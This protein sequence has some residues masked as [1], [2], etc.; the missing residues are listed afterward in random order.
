[1]TLTRLLDD[2]DLHKLKG[3]DFLKN[4]PE[5]ADSI[6]TVLGLKGKQIIEFENVKG[7]NIYGTMD[8]ADILK[9]NESIELLRKAD[10]L[11]TTLNEPFSNAMINKITNAARG[12]GAF[13]P[14]EVFDK[15]ISNGSLRQLDSF[16]K[17]VDDFDQHLMKSGESDLATN[18]NRVKTQTAQRLFKNA[19]ED[20]IDPVTNEIN[21]TV[22]AKHILK[23]ESTHP[24]K[25]DSLFRAPDGITSG[26]TIVQTINQ[27]IKISPKLKADNVE[28]LISVFR[29]QDGLNTT[30]K[31]KAFIT[32]LKEQAE[33]SA[34]EADL[35][36]NRNLSE[37]PNRTPSE[38][39]E[40][41]FRP[42]NSQNIIK[43][44]QMMEPDDFAKVKEA[45]LGKLLEDAIDYNVKSGFVTDIFKSKN[46]NTALNKYSDET[47]EAM[48]GKEFTKDIKH[49]ADTIDALTKGEIGRGNFPGALV[50]AGIAAGVVFAPLAAI[51]TI[52]GLQIA[53]SLLGSRMFIKYAS[54]TDKGSIIKALEILRT[55]AA[56]FGYRFING[57]LRQVQDNTSKFIEENVPDTD[58]NEIMGLNKQFDAPQTN[59][60]L[61]QVSPVRLADPLNQSQQDRIEFAEKLFRRPI[62]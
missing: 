57:E 62:I 40:T 47:L 13:D 58:I 35:L 12:S 41:I 5:N 61:P 4:N 34:K 19:F 27:L 7:K 3:E 36:A 60:S 18:L 28:D 53:K 29:G 42:K 33:A 1:M 24:G 56:Q 15:L 52:F 22:F 25:I 2:A 14:D 6:F 50:A 44:K 32:A 31:G 8:Y 46:L 16:F 39:V 59:I 9:V 54:R 55:T 20:S 48:F 21:Y 51:P 10:R 23:F 11:N 49:F 17:A 43:L 30:V 38:I 37:L 45:S 26:P